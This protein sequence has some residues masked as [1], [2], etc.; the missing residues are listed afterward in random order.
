MIR[1]HTGLALGNEVYTQICF[2]RLYTNMPPTAQAAA[3]TAMCV[4]ESECIAYIIIMIMVYL[5]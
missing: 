5:M 4:Q 2:I 3:A 1:W